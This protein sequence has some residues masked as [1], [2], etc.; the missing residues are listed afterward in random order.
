MYFIYRNFESDYWKMPAGLLSNRP[1]GR[2]RG[3]RNAHRVRW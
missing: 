2:R 3:Q 1:H